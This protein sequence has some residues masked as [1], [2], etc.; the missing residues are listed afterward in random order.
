MS[1]PPHMPMMTPIPFFPPVTSMM[2]PPNMATPPPGIPTAPNG[3]LKSGDNDKKNRLQ[4]TTTVFVGSISDRAPEVMMKRMLQHCGS[5]VNWKRVQGANGKLQAFGFCEYENPESTLRCI[6]LLNGWQ[7]QDKKLVVKVDAKTKALL[8]EY[9]K[10]KRHELAKKAANDTTAFKFIYED[11]ED[12]KKKSNSTDADGKKKSGE[13]GEIEEEEDDYIDDET[14]REDFTIKQSLETVMRE[15]SREMNQR[16]LEAKEMAARE[17]QTTTLPIPSNLSMPPLPIP[18][19]STVMPTAPDVSSVNPATRRTDPADPL[20]DEEGK[21]NL[22]SNEIQMFRNRFKDEDTKMRNTEKERKDRYERERALQREKRAAEEATSS[23][24]HKFGSSPSSRGSPPPSFSSRDRSS[25]RREHSSSTSRRDRSPPSDDRYRNSSSR[26]NTSNS[27]R[28]RTNDRRSSPPSRY[29]RRSP[30]PPSRP[31]SRRSR[32]KSPVPKSR[33]GGGGNNEE[34][35]EE[36]YER[37]KQES[38]LQEKE[39]RYRARLR[40][41]EQRER[42]R[43]AVYEAEKQRELGRLH[44]EEKEAKHLLSFLEEYNDETDDPKYYKGTALANRLKDREHE[45]EIDNRDRHREKDEIEVLRVKLLQ[46]NIDDIELEIKR[47]L[48]REE[49]NIRKR[50][51]ELIKATS[52][53]SSDESENEEEKAKKTSSKNRKDAMDMSNNLST[54]LVNSIT[55][56]LSHSS[57]TTNKVESPPNDIKVS[58]RHT[59][60]LGGAPI[61]GTKLPSKRKLAVNEVFRDDQDDDGTNALPKKSRLFAIIDQPTTAP[62]IPITQNSPKHSIPHVKEEPMHRTSSK[63]TPPA[64]NANNISAQ[65]QEEKRQAV[66]KLIESIPTKKEDLFTFALDWSLLDPNLME[67]RIKPWVTKKIVEYIGE[68]EPTLTDF[69]CTSIMS[70]KSADSILAD[71][72]VVLDDEAEVFVVKMW[73]LIVYEIEAKRHGL[74]K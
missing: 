30:V 27:V 8:D 55:D 44:D 69:I 24:N 21:R 56:S 57:R 4:P 12:D 48:E 19:N 43:G 10:K 41:W 52:D 31:Y 72:R 6:R 59:S 32:T 38:R 63:Q 60:A 28:S 5:V 20:D 65:S 46:E 39:A 40:A 73:R 58:P 54:D 26:N 53:E 34:D 22:I 14:R 71:I 45:I 18:S 15:Y 47:R 50:L 42:K 37:R 2:M 33:V 36:A 61:T 3:T 64:S 25:P 68:E 9:K 49:E 67:K 74:S 70:K 1:F 7:I 13:E 23:E 62:Q 66:R 35:T 16:A 29:E 51:V 11:D 17:A